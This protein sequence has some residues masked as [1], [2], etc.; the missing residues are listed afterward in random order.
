MTEAEIDCETGGPIGCTAEE[1]GY[2]ACMSDFVSRT[3]CVQAGTSE[4]CPA[5]QF[6]FG[7][8]S[9]EIPSGCTP[10]ET[11]AA[12]PYACCPPFPD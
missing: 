3:G 6:S 5:G 9:G 7:C 4:E 10:F 8:L 12:V 2:F 11:G 1:T